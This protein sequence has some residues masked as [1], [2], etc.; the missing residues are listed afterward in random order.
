MS[1]PSPSPSI[2]DIE[3]GV[4]ESQTDNTDELEPLLSSITIRI[5]SRRRSRGNLENDHEMG[6]LMDQLHQILSSDPSADNTNGNG[7]QLRL[8]DPMLMERQIRM[9]FNDDTISLA[10]R[11]E[12]FLLV[13]AVEWLRLVLECIPILLLLVVS[14]M[15]NNLPCNF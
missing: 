2:R 13:V 14:L 6:R 9:L 3:T 15:V 11:F 1:N 4:R 7:R 10:G 12:S 8:N 5:H